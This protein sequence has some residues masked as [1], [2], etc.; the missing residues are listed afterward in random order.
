M[1]QDDRWTALAKVTQP[2][3]RVG[4]PTFK[5]GLSRGGI[6]LGVLFAQEKF[7]DHGEVVRW[8]ESLLALGCGLVRLVDHNLLYLAKALAARCI[9]S[10]DSILLRVFP[11]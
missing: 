10:P 9:D 3:S 6:W 11:K 1:A 8:V 7:G 4:E 2:G 5:N